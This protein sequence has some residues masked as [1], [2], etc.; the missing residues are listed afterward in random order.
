MVFCSYIIFVGSGCGEPELK[1]TQ[2]STAFSNAFGPACIWDLVMVNEPTFDGFS[3]YDRIM[4][5]YT[6]IIVW[7]NNV[8]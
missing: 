5:G 6:Q 1:A 3:R 4:M 2:T 8:S 7:T